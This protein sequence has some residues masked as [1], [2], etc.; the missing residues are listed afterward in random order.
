MVSL[1][2]IRTA[3]TEL[4][5]DYR[6]IVK[7][8]MFFA[9]AGA[10][11]LDELERLACESFSQF[12]GI[13]DRGRGADELGVAS[14]EPADAGDA[15]EEIREVAAEDAAIGVQLIDDD[16][17]EVLEQLRPLRVVRKDALME[18]V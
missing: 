14:I 4:L 1:F 6:R 9:F 18:H 8:E 12:L 11:F 13:G 15:T 17:L 2:D 3:N 10:V 7:E 5:I 16:K